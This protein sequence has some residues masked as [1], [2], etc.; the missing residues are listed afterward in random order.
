MKDP[1]YNFPSCSNEEELNVKYVIENGLHLSENCF[2]RNSNYTENVDY[3][4]ECI[5][6]SELKKTIEDGNMSNY[7]NVKLFSKEWIKWMRWK[8]VGENGDGGKGVRV[9]RE[10]E[11]EVRVGKRKKRKPQKIEGGVKE[12]RSWSGDVVGL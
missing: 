11:E 3:D 7:S 9:L 4:L 8:E 12:R 2:T 1:I 10:E 6:F 5:N